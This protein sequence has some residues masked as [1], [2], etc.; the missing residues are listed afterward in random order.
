MVKIGLESDSLDLAIKGKRVALVANSA[1]VDCNGNSSI[2]IV[3]E[4]ANLVAL[5]ALE[6]G[7]RGNVSAGESVDDES[8]EIPII[9]LYKG[10]GIALDKE[11]C[12]E[13]D[14][15]VFDIQDLGL[16]FYTYLASLKMIISSC[17][18]NNVPLIVLDRP[19]PLGR[20]V[21]GNILSSDSFSFVGPDSLPIR[22][23]LTLGEMA[24]FF[25]NKLEKK[26]DLTVIKLTGWHGE[27]W[28]ETGRKWI[29]TSPNIPDFET[30]F[31]YAGTCLFEGL[32]I[33]EGRGTDA[34]FRLIGAPFVDLDLLLP[35]IDALHLKGVEIEG[36][37]YIPRTN[38]FENIP[39][40]G[41]RIHVVDYSTFDPVM[42][43]LNL[44]VLFFRLFKETETIKPKEDGVRMIDRLFGKGMLDKLLADDKKTLE[45]IK[46]DSD[47]FSSYAVNYY[48][49]R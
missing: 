20:A 9:S 34:P 6:H 30:A 18:E 12:K 31:V 2:D 25:N 42:F 45:E 46:K 1:S 19:A 32:N 4:K 21:S 8:G 48:L 29:A 47:E 24:Y 3:K 35:A 40:H 22:Y 28:P 41:I 15:I 10:D 33:S 11:L 27:M 5:L 37:D 16:R 38:K 14:A 39:C 7:I 13:L 36:C 17:S 26:A 49:Y 23:G 43:S 44:I